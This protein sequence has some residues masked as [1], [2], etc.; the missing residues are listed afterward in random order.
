M[1]DY[2]AE[3]LELVDAW[4]NELNEMKKKH[5]G[6]KK[7]KITVDVLSKGDPQ[8]LR[9]NNDGE[10]VYI[11]GIEGNQVVLSDPLGRQRVVSKTSVAGKRLG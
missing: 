2:Y 4:N 6:K 1:N 11:D 8:D 7:P 5:G 10:D 3:H 9:I